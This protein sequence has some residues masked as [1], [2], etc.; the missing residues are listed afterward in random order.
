MVTPGASEALLN[1]QK[2]AVSYAAEPSRVELSCLRATMVSEHG[3]RRLEFAAGAWKCS[4]EFFS[5]HGTC[6]HVMALEMILHDQAGLS[7]APSSEDR[8]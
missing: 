6:S 8:A 1:K 7:F 3:V 2:K 5:D 4:C